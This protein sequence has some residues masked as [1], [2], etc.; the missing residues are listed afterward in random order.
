MFEV[1]GAGLSWQ[2][3]MYID[4]HDFAAHRRGGLDG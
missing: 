3:R 1:R 4:S 2:D